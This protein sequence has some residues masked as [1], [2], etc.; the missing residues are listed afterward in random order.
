[1]QWSVVKILVQ[2]PGLVGDGRSVGVGVE[3]DDT[4][5]DG[6]LPLMAMAR[7]KESIVMRNL[8]VRIFEVEIDRTVKS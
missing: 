6:M 1:V 2:I 7:S 8:M 5:G 4:L 3:D